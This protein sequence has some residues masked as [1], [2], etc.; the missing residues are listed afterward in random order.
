MNNRPR[1]DSGRIFQ[2]QNRN[3]LGV[4]LAFAIQVRNISKIRSIFGHELASEVSS[5]LEKSLEK[6]CAEDD[7]DGSII[8]RDI[9]VFDLFIGQYGFDLAQNSAAEAVYKRLDRWC[10]DA[11]LKIYEGGSGQFLLAVVIRQAQPIDGIKSTQS[12]LDCAH[13]TLRLNSYQL[14][15]VSLDD[16]AYVTEMLLAVDWVKD[17]KAGRLSFA[18][19]PIRNLQ[20]VDTIAHFHGHLCA[21]SSTGAVIGPERRLAA[22]RHL[23]LGSTVDLTVLS[24]A[25]D[26]ACRSPGPPLLIEMFASTLRLSFWQVSLLLS[27]IATF[28][29]DRI[30][31]QI[32]PDLE[33]YDE[34]V[35]SSMMELHHHGVGLGVEI[36]HSNA[37][38]RNMMLFTQPQFIAI[39][40]IFMRAVLARPWNMEAISTI[41][42]IAQLIAPMVVL[43]GIDTVLL[44]TNARRAGIIWGEGN[45]LGLPSWLT[46]RQH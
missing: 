25:L 12:G 3:Q 30:R 31:L 13:A 23:G 14:F 20:D 16:K 29:R 22:I 17:L 41:Y 34:E 7:F 43:Q 40:P 39:S 35:A 46:P 38:Y 42:A 36:C 18:W 24:M 10:R 8:V 1:I 5:S 2:G 19:T 28:G 37:L 11:S 15:E 6:I 32:I 44:A 45:Y 4:C 26:I 33:E 9:G 27:S 21:M